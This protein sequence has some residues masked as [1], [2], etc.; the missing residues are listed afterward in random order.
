[1][2]QKNIFKVILILLSLL[3][4]SDL[5][6]VRSRKDYFLKP[7]VGFWFGPITPVYTTAED[8]DT[9]IGGGVFMRYNTPFKPL[10]I[11]FDV[12]YQRFESPGVNKL[13]AIPL[14]GTF[15]YLL[16]FQLPVKLQIKAGA[17]AGN[18]YIEPDKSRQWDPLFVGGVEMSFPA[19]RYI[20]IGLRIDYIFFYEGYADGATRGGHIV[21]AG[22]SL[23]FNINL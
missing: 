13:E 11:G 16:P 1:M 18:V 8:L 15:I 17:G 3:S 10:K 23:Y 12:S 7:Q 9:A 14:Y 22:L 20:N 2:N 5:F 4:A 19:G 21:N 6:A